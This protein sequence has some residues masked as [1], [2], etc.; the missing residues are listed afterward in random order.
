MLFR[1]GCDPAGARRVLEA[2][3]NFRDQKGRLCKK[4]LKHWAT[5]FFPIPILSSATAREGRGYDSV[6]NNASR[7]LDSDR[8][9]IDRAGKSKWYIASRGQKPNARASAANAY[10]R[11][12]RSQRAKQLWRGTPSTR[13]Q[14]RALNTFAGK[15]ITLRHQQINMCE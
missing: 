7:F 11:I 15:F 13:V 4:R 2:E 3:R 14:L 10:L 5:V 9:Y 6:T 1:S 8:M 12:A